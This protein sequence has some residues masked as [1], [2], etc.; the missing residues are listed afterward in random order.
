MT[1]IG[2]VRSTSTTTSPLN[3]ARSYTQMTASLYR[4]K[5]AFSRASHLSHSSVLDPSSRIL[6]AT[7]G[8]HTSDWE[9]KYGSC[10]KRFLDEGK[11]NVGIEAP[12]TQKRLLH[13]RHLELP[14]LLHRRHGDAGELQSPE[15]FLPQLG[16]DDMERPVAALESLLDERKQDTVLL[17]RVVKKGA[18]MT[19]C[20]KHRAREPNRSVPPLA[21]PQRAMARSLVESIGPHSTGL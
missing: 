14:A 5:I 2:C 3:L 20:A 19:L 11:H 15:M 4:S 1:T 13:R 18:D 17:V 10:I 6:S 9:S 12:T 7:C 21:T 16:L 8:N